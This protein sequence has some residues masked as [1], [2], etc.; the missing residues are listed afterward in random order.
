M[1]KPNNTST[2]NELL[3]GK[4][5]IHRKH[6]QYTLK[7]SAWLPLKKSWVL[8]VIHLHKLWNFPCV[9]GFR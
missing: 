2:L 8:V 3:V 9:V 6:I 7:C 4:L 1:L 5:T